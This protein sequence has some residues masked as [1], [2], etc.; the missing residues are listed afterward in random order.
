MYSVPDRDLWLTGTQQKQREPQFEIRLN[1]ANIISEI[2]K[3]SKLYSVTYGDPEKETEL[4]NN[5]RELDLKQLHDK[6]GE[7]RRDFLENILQH[8]LKY[9]KLFVS[10]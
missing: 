3:T 9:E 5:S 4:G 8:C 10:F 7:N 6:L 2:L 1:S